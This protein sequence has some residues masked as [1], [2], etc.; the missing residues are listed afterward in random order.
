MY[1][2]VYNFLKVLHAFTFRKVPHELLQACHVCEYDKF[3]VKL[4]LFLP[5]TAL[6]E[7]I[8]ESHLPRLSSLDP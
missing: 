4:P 1:R 3:N 8:Q 5:V 6:L 2:H 7:D